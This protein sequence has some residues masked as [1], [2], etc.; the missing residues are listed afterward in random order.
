M[1]ALPPVSTQATDY[2]RWVATLDELFAGL[3][4]RLLE[5][6]LGNEKSLTSEVWR[7]FLMLMAAALV[8]EALLCLPDRRPVSQ[9]G[10]SGK[11]PA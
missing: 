1:L 7:T 3:D 4:W 8:L 6:T 11:Q 2:P 5:R 9:A 10:D